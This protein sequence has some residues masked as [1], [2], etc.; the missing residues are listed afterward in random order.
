MLLPD[1]EKPSIATIMRGVFICIYLFNEAC[2]SHVEVY[3]KCGGTGVWLG[4]RHADAE[5]S[6]ADAGGH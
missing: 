1:E 2:E 4:E 5:I 6:P 3:H